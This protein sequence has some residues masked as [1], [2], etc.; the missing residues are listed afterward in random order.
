MPSRQPGKCALQEIELTADVTEA[1]ALGKQQHVAGTV[2]LPPSPTASRQIVIFA[3]PG[4]GY[5]RGYF[6]MHFPDR[7]GYSEAEYHTGRGIIFVAMDHLGVGDSSLDSMDDLT[8]EAIADANHA[9]VQHV[10]RRL[11][12]GTLADA[13]PAVQNPFVVGIGQSM[14]GGITMIMQGRCAT[15]HAIA[16]LGISA[17][18]T[19]LPQPTPEQFKVARDLF[20]FSRQTPLDQLAVGQT[21]TR[22]PDFIYPFHW[23]DEP[24]DIREADMA[25][26]YPLRRTSPKFGSLTIPR[27]A[28]AMNSPGFYTP[29]VSH[30]T[31]PVLMAFG[32]RD[33]SADM[34]REATAFFNSN[35]ISIFI[36]PR[37]AH[38]HNFA[39]TRHVLWQRVADWA[40]MQAQL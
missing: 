19:V 7:E 23:D 39:E 4:G 38:M 6:D 37:M 32:E 40:H 17:I 33:V 9:F 1:A 13:F 36:L 12:A 20:M 28:V 18:H 11:T 8:V 31:V 25:G 16:P 26:G 5:S 2:F 15:F 3:S 29:E 14:G 21:G 30:I 22:V 35:D 24:E 27:C 34:R 10:M